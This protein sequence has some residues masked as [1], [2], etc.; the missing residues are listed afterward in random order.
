M[1]FLKG[2]VEFLG[3]LKCN[4][5][6]VFCWG[7]L[8][9]L[10]CVPAE[11]VFIF[12]RSLPLLSTGT[13]IIMLLTKSANWQRAQVGHH[14]GCSPAVNACSRI[15]TSLKKKWGKSCQSGSRLYIIGTI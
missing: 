5:D 2:L 9:V 7:I 8:F 4:Q 13:S 3:S 15:N 14:E 1:H 10:F 11:V 6:Q 12:L